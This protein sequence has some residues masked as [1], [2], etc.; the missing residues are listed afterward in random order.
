MEEQFFTNPY[1]SQMDEFLN[2]SK[3]IWYSKCGGENA[4]LDITIHMKNSKG[5]EKNSCSFPLPIKVDLVYND[6]SPTPFMPLS[7]LKERKSTVTS[8]NP[9][10]RPMRPPPVLEPYVTNHSF[11]FR[12]EEVSSHHAEY[13]GF[14]LKVSLDYDRLKLMN[15]NTYAPWIVPFV[16][17][18][19]LDETIIV[20]SKPN[21]DKSAEKMTSLHG[22][23][24]LL[25]RESFLR[26]LYQNN[27]QNYPSV[28][29]SEIR[30]VNS[31]RKNVVLA[32]RS[33][34]PPRKVSL[35]SS[36]SFPTSSSMTSSIANRSQGKFIAIT[37]LKHLVMTHE[38]LC[39]WCKSHLSLSDPFVI[40]N[41]ASSCY[42]ICE[43]LPNIMMSPIVKEI[44][45]Q[46]QSSIIT[47]NS[48]EIQYEQF[49]VSTNKTSILVHPFAAKKSA[50]KKSM[51][52]YSDILNRD[53]SDGEASLMCADLAGDN[54]ELSDDGSVEEGSV[55]LNLFD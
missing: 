23:R 55:L 19:L 38:S 36:N 31:I 18:G 2:A 49:R 15:T 24:S 20:R 28:L 14:K 53:V 11:S 12:I 21:L 45:Q 42:F 25:R 26:R 33:T 46:N 8:K 35:M 27:H 44:Y 1:V 10:F 3:F 7:P 6:G 16:H 34:P 54:L 29:F 52:F 32:N 22:G 41:H 17:P 48:D 37:N 13:I 39:L 43:M 4:G 30:R 47:P 9:L 50:T 40:E 51:T 5:H